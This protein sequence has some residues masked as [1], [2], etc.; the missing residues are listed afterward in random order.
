MLSGAVEWGDLENNPL[1]GMKK[2][3]VARKRNIRITLEQ[4]EALLK[5]MDKPRTTPNRLR[6]ARFAYYTGRRLEGVQS[7]RMENLGACQIYC[8]V[9]S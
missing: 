8:Y 2:L 3:K 1:R 4:V 7:L 9:Q 5:E 6:M